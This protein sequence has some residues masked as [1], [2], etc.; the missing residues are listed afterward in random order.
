MGGE[1]AMDGMGIENVV[2]SRTAPK[3]VYVPA[4]GACDYVALAE[5]SL[6]L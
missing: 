3:D 2:G 1:R 6:Q 5:G 4:S